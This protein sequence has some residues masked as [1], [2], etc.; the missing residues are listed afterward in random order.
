MKVGGSDMIGSLLNFFHGYLLISI[1]GNA[2]ERFVTQIIEKNIDLWNLKRIKKNYYQAQIKISD[3]KKLRPLV[4][5]RLCRV[6]IVRK[7][8]LPF[9]IMRAR[10]R[11]F[12]V[13]GFLLILVILWFASSFVWFINI[14][15][16]EKI[17]EE[18]IYNI[19]SET[20]VK[21]GILKSR[22]DLSEIEAD[23]LR[24]EP[25]LIWV[26]LMWQGTRLNVELVEKKVVEKV[27]SPVIVAAKDGQITEII[28]LRGRAA[29]KE[30]DTVTAGQTLIVSIQ[31]PNGDEKEARGIVRAHVWYK[32]TAMASLKLRQPVYTG[33]RKTI[34][35]LKYKSYLFHLLS[36]PEFEAYVLEKEIKKLPE[37]RNIDFPLEFVIEKYQE[38]EY[39]TE[40]RGRELALFIARQKALDKILDRLRPQSVIIDVQ[41]REIKCKDENKV[42]VSIL[43]KAEEN[44]AKSKEG[45][46]G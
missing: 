36:R 14:E 43:L 35:G 3:F 40:N 6:R 45:F 5:R 31:Q 12:L 25:R 15:G 42:K 37:W 26:D 9:I 24:Q 39:L 8:G 20:G 13:I 27:K 30:G 28:V 29:I 38:V 16:L 4:R 7:C 23:I 32:E 10:N 44:I 11:Y 33:A 41:A 46:S 34:W 22:L 17:S 19:L 1:H 18:R 2:L 21:P